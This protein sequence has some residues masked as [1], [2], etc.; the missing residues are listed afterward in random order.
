MFVAIKELMDSGA[1]GSKRVDSEGKEGCSS[2]GHGHAEVRV[3]VTWLGV[4]IE[5][6]ANA[7]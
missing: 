1:T 7:I 4:A 5:L 3:A 2:L 6:F